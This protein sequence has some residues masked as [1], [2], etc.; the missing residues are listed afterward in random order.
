MESTCL[1]IWVHD[2]VRDEV[3]RP[4]TESAISYGI[5]CE[6]KRCYPWRECTGIVITLGVVN[7]KNET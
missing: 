3:K 6:R 7:R 5:E 4:T 1:L 2:V